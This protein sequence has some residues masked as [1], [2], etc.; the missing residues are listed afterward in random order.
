MAGRG[1][2]IAVDIGGTK[3]RVALVRDSKII[4]FAQKP[5]PSKKNDIL[6]EMF[7]LIYKVMGKNVRGIGVSSPGPLENGKI[8]NTLNLDLAYFDLRSALKKK[9]NIRVEVENDASCVALA[10]SKLGVKKNNFFVLTLGTGIG[11]GVIID[12]RLFKK[13]NMRG[14]LG[15]IFLDKDKDF[16]YLV[17]TKAIKRMTKNAFGKELVISDLM[18]MKD[19][20]AK[21]ILDEITEYFG[22]GIGSLINIFNPEIVVLA[23]GYHAAGDDF[24]HLIRKKVSKYIILPKNYPIEWSKLKE[25]GI[26]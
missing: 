1:E 18:K 24:L 25:P 15:H 20:R 2:V 22:Q 19:K 26:L 13:K 7:G 17:G 14:E 16:E 6:K 11:G 10:E 5:T 9:F 3:L 12:G 23:G 21:K 4:N 8:L